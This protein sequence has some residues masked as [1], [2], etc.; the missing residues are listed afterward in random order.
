MYLSDFVA[1][2]TNINELLAS[3]ISNLFM[4]VWFV[5]DPKQEE[6]NFFLASLFGRKKIKAETL[7]G[8]IV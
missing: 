2:W 8:L 6:S 1:H 7:E 3:R 5:Y 4:N